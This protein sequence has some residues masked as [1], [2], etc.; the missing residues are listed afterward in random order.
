MTKNID[1][2]LN[3]LDKA[4][5][6]HIDDMSRNT[7]GEVSQDIMADLRHFV[8]HIMFKIY[9]TVED[10]DYSYEN[11]VKA[12]N[13]IFKRG[14]Y[15]L[16]SNF[17][18]MLE[19]VVSHYKPSEESSERLMIKYFEYL[20]RIKEFMAEQFNFEILENLEKF[21]LNM[22]PQF[23]EFYFQISKK[24][25]S[26]N[27]INYE[28]A[29]MYRI[30]KIK[31]FFVNNNL[32]YE[33]SFSPIN[34]SNK[35]NRIIAF[36]KI[37][38]ESNY[39]SKLSLCESKITVNKNEMPILIIVGWQISIRKCEF[40]NFIKL[41]DCNHRRINEYER[42]SI[43]DYMTQNKL[44]LV[45]IIELQ[46]NEYMILKQNLQSKSKVTNF[47]NTLDVCRN[48]I[49][50]G[51]SGKN[52]LKYILYSMDNV[53]IKNQ[54]NIESN[55]NLSN[56]Y[57]KNGVIPFDNLP[58]TFSLIKHNP[59]FNTLLKCFDVDEHESEMLYKHVKNNTESKGQIFTSV[60]DIDLPIENLQELVNNYNDKLWSGH[61]PDNELKIDKG[62][63]FIKKYVEECRFII[64]MLKEFS[65]VGVKNYTKS[66]NSWLENSY[67][68]IDSI[69]KKEVLKKIFAESK[70]ALIYGA[71]GTGKTTLINHIAHLFSDNKKM[72]LAQTN[73]AVDNL[74]RKVNSANCDFYTVRRF[75]E[76]K[77][78]ISD[79][80][81]LIIDECSTI[82]N[83]DMKSILKRS[84]F[85]LLIL[86]GDVC[87]IESIRFGN[88]FRL[89]KNFLPKKSII[90]LKE[91]FRTKDKY[92]LSLWNSVRNMDN[93]VLERL[94]KNH[95]SSY[96]DDSIFTPLSNDEIILCSNYDGLYGINN[97]NRLLQD[98][99][100][101][102]CVSWGIH[103]FKV[104]DPI[105]FQET[106]RFKPIIYN[107][108]KGKI[109]DVNIFNKG[110]INERIEFDIEL[111]KIINEMNVVQGEFELLEDGTY[112]N[113][114]NSVIRFSI[115]KTKDVE[116]DEIDEKTV[117]PFQIAYAVSIHKSQGLEYKSVKVVITNEVDE[118][119]SHNIF[120]TAITRS[121]SILKIYWTPEV[122]NKII[123]KLIPRNSNKD[124]HLLYS[125][126]I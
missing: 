30:N 109:L 94:N 40:N 51:N 24:I 79:F 69:E 73:P 101:N 77:I 55:K 65:Y 92:L 125:V 23:K 88:W 52:I 81:I 16:L 19:I 58:F 45:D 90:E 105:L 37:K 15:K 46:D 102:K 27:I 7:R 20:Y 43:C 47:I 104:G 26:K 33:V 76:S 112:K 72:F 1:T 62:Q 93:T 83:S 61:R 31:P 3:I 107:N 108:L 13:Y 60:K 103:K 111:D 25:E 116:A 121:R 41:I 21:P 57:L 106:N 17:H 114:E 9:L 119:I 80:D 59:P 68:G 126:E 11:I 84:S 87:Q 39:V 38:L 49:R 4:I 124:F 56:L 50:N 99:N 71:A 12:K 64:D 5:C 95:Y 117:I 96:L 123:S 48:I 34:N 2:E 98:R 29:E 74:K 115:Y 97:I 110:K 86:V 78:N 14:E 36:T 35:T 82:S 67:S 44:N 120:Y 28:N 100:T 53:V 18:K 63:I 22:D 6:R 70:V 54:Y 75:N 32:Y 85:K 42:E 8:E 91:Y 118:M 10:V 66:V 89:A 122:E 113:V